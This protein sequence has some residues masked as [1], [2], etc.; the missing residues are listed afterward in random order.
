MQ[1]LFL[2]LHVLVA[3]SLIVLVLLQQ[4]RGADAG[5]GFGGGASGTVFGARGAASFLTRTTAML[6]TAFFISS[7]ILAYFAT[8]ASG[9]TSVVENSV[10]EQVQTAPA[11]DVPPPAAVEIIEDANDVPAAPVSE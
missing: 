10:M 7:L 6:A 11:T 3:I 5:S 4:G 9:P 2:V 8:Q 1:Q